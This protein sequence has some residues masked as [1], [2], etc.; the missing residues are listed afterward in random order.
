MRNTFGVMMIGS[1]S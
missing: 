1:I